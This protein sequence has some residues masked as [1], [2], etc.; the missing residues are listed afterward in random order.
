MSNPLDE[1]L[2]ISRRYLRGDYLPK[3]LVCLD[4]LGDE[5]VWWRMNEA[6][7]SIGN[8]VLHLSGNARQWIVSGVG[9]APDS[10]KRQTEFDQR[11]VIPRADL[12]GR[13]RST[14]MEVDDTL[15]A[16]DPT[17]LLDTRKIQ[18]LDTTVMGA[19]YHVVEHFST[20]TGQIVMLT[21]QRT[22]TDLGFWEARADG[23]VA[24]RWEPL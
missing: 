1:F 2:L 16:V 21:K 10:R 19:I 7:N 13:L 12:A 18:G 20:H 9:G 17:R 5:D 3:I 23:T 22:G 14:M 15:A 8:L 11:A 6:S 4:K 24:R